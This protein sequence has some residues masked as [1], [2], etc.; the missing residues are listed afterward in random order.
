MGKLGK[1]GREEA[2]RTRFSLPHDPLGAFC[3]DN[4]VALPGSGQGPLR[5]LTFAV[6][7]LF[8]IRGHRTGFGHPD[9][10]RTHPPEKRTALAVRRLL[11][12]GADLAGRTHCDELCYSLTGENVHYGAPLNPSAPGR[13]PGGSSN[14]SAAA[15]A[16]GL[17]DFALGSDCGGSVRIPA[18]YCGILGMRPSWGRVPLDHAVPFGPSFDVAGWFARDAA[19]LE[20]V[21]RV[22]LA[23]RNKAATPKRLLVARDAFAMVEGAVA[24][25]LAPA[26]GW[27]KKVI[28]A[29]EEIE[30]APDGLVSWF[31]AFRTL[32][33]AEVWAS[34]GGWV[35]QVKPTLGPGVKERIA[36]AAKVT[37]RMVAQ[38]NRQRSKAR[39]RLQRLMAPQDVLCLPTSPR[40]APPLGTPLDKIEI[41]YRKEAMCL[42]SIAGLAG[43]PQLSLPM[44]RIDGL[45][46]GLSIIG[47]NGADTMLLSIALRIAADCTTA[48]RS[49]ARLASSAGEAWPQHAS[50]YAARA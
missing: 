22:L 43:L 3:R 14:G 7:D 6:K 13:I 30:V 23:D 34:V 24:R 40:V 49:R 45:P 36:W 32:Q 42:L 12:A 38:A 39:T 26:L 44:G 5:G 1:V 19:V 28:G 2:M 33:A 21:G 17:V 48:S 47:K 35:R 18:S 15:V 8:H 4:H 25:A 10:L 20:K 11:A 41:S 50:R 46:I 37:P 31:E 16:G 29:S 9:W 27:L